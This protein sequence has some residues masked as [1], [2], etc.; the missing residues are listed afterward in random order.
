DFDAGAGQYHIRVRHRN[1]LSGTTADPITL[2]VDPIEVDLTS[3]NTPTFG[4]DAQLMI[5]SVMV[6]WPGNAN[7]DG[8]VKDAGSDNDRDHVLVAV[9]GT[10]RTAIANGYFN[11][12]INMDGTV[13]YAGLGNDRDVILQTIGGTIPTAI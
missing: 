8:M 13:K 7:G 11:A 2:G 9:G 5:D 4:T 1:H 10:E 3:P 6:M 12:D